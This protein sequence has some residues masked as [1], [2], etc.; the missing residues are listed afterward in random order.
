M[1]KNKNIENGRL[2]HLVLKALAYLVDDINVRFWKSDTAGVLVPYKKDDDNS[3]HQDAIKTLDL[4]ILP[5]HRFAKLIFIHTQ[6]GKNLKTLVPNEKI[7]PWELLQPPLLAMSKENKEASIDK[8]PLQETSHSISS[9][10]L[11][12]NFWTR[13]PIELILKINYLFLWHKTHSSQINPIV[14]SLLQ[15]DTAQLDDD[16][17]SSSVKS[18]DSN[19][20][21]PDDEGSMMQF[22]EALIEKLSYAIN[23]LESI[24]ID[25]KYIFGLA[26]MA[27]EGKQVNKTSYY[28]SFKQG[29]ALRILCNLDDF[30]KN[31]KTARSNM[32]PILVMTYELVL[33]LKKKAM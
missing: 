15:E 10:H 19:Q 16:M 17:V 14:K 11:S 7:Y 32:G 28:A 25:V 13:L 30:S 2:H 29:K 6:P 9:V 33:E 18:Y 12:E 3:L 20:S 31:F 1:I 4:L 23:K 21:N 24:G 5:N 27:M 8:K 22:Q 26:F